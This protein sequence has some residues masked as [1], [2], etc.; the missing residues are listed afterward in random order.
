VA[1]LAARVAR[2]GLLIALVAAFALGNAASALAPTFETLVVARFLAGLPHGA[3]FGISAVLAAGLVPAERRGRAIAITLS[4]LT[5]A[6]LLGVPATAWLGQSL[7]RT[8]WP[9][10]SLPL[11]LAVFGLG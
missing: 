5:V 1:V 11:V 2:T 10:G 3:Y 9:V 4:G 6:N 7:G 8:G